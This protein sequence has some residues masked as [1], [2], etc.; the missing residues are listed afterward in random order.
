[1]LNVVRVSHER[2]SL[3]NYFSQADAKKLASCQEKSRQG[4]FNDVN[5]QLTHS[6][7]VFKFPYFRDLWRKTTKYLSGSGKCFSPFTPQY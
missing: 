3:R 4:E 5:L 6:F 2:F 7:D 1:M